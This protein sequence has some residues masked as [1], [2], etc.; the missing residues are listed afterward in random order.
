M[1]VVRGL[2]AT[3]LLAVGLW[4]PYSTGHFNGLICGEPCGAQYISAPD[5]MRSHRP[6]ALSPIVAAPSSMN[7]RAVRAALSAALAHAPLGAHAGVAVGDLSGGVTQLGDTGGLVPAS[8]VKL[9]T[10]FAALRLLDP[11]SRF[12]TRAELDGQRVILVGGGDPYLTTGRAPGAGRVE[13]ADLGTLARRTAAALRVLGERRVSLGYDDSMFTGP[14]FNEAWETRYRPH[15]V[16]PIGALWAEQGVHNGRVDGNPARE[17]AERFAVEL[18]RAGIE[19]SAGLSQLTAPPVATRLAAVRSATV[20]QIVQNVELYSD[21]EGAEVLG[22]HVALAA[23]RPASFAGAAQAIVAQMVAANIDADGLRLD[24]ASGLSRHDRIP[25]AVL[26]RVLAQAARLPDAAGLLADLPVAHVS[27]SLAGRFD[28]EPGS[29]GLLRAKTGTLAGVHALA[30]LVTTRDG[31]LLAFSV[32][33][34]ATASNDAIVVAGLDAV[35]GAL[36]DCDC[37]S[38]SPLG[39]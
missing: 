2:A 16:T 8:T 14:G 38:T 9:L 7:P 35:A 20:A 25:P 17:A 30:G 1:A 3:A 10:G 24:D 22:R 4:W 23:G 19:V 12:V 31:Q 39:N 11:Q 36:A 29:W 6:A 21:N 18:R 32:M 13:R 33:A 34:D 37:G 26:V 5:A 27:G 28:A 15:V